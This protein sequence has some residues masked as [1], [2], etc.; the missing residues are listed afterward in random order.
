[1]VKSVKEEDEANIHYYTDEIA[2][3][4][5]VNRVKW[6]DFYPSERWIF[7]RVAGR[8]RN[9]GRILDVGCAVGGLW[10]AL[11]KRFSVTEYVGVDINPKA[12]EI[13]NSSKSSFP[14]NL[15]RFECND[16]LE[17]N[18]L[19][20]EGFDNVFS[21]SCADWNILTRDII[22]ECWRYVKKDGHFILTLRLTPETSLYNI[23]ES[24]QYICFKDKVVDCMDGCE[25]APYVVLN[26]HD[27]LFMLSE[28]DPKPVQVV[29]YGYWGNPSPTARTLYKRLCFTA[30]AVKKGGHNEQ[31]EEI[32]GEFHLPV[33]LLI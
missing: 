10:C 12:I 24:F 11:A 7:E 13:A 1:L 18:S 32:K 21:L 22:R 33:D 8:A 9:M 2:R 26:I 29:A 6:E 27:A 30:L 23:S 16:I 31:L 5:A 3:Y 19:P 28:L 17:M 15:C 14:I 4:Y 25:K 20:V